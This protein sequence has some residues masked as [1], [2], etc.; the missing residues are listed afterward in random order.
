M[1]DEPELAR[2][3]A[4]S[5]QQCIAFGERAGQKVRATWIS[6]DITY[7]ALSTTLFYH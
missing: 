4:A 1:A 3:L 2:T 5:V 7:F 6:A